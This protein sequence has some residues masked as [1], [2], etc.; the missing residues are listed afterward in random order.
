MLDAAGRWTLP[1]FVSAEQH[2]AEV[3]LVSRHIRERY[4]LHISIL[5]TVASDYDETANRVRK[6]YLAE[7][8]TETAGAGRW[9]PR[10]AV[11]AG[12]A[13]L[14][15]EA[16]SLVERWVT[17]SLG[18]ADAVWSRPGWLAE[19][20]AW[21]ATKAGQIID[22]EQVRVSEFSTVVRIVAG[23]RLC[24]FK[25]VAPAAA[26]EPPVT[27]ALARRTPHVPP[28]LAA[29]AARRFLLLEAFAG[30]PLATDDVAVWTGVARD[31]GELQR[32]CIDAVGE[33][34][35]MGCDVTRARALVEPLPALLANDDA[36]LVGTPAGLTTSEIA[37]LRTLAPGL[38][39][40]A[41]ALDAGPL[42]LTVDHGDLWPSNVLV[43][44]GGCA[45][46][47]WEDARIAHPFVSTFQLLAGAHMDHRFADEM[48]AY[49]AV[50][51]AYLA[52]WSGWAPAPSLRKAFDIAHDVAAV[53]VAASYRRYPPD[54]VAAHPWMREM[55]PFCLRRILT[56]RA[57]ADAPGP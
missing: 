41:H 21:V 36:L 22:V 56:R 38:A 16:H 7:A 55:P 14:R 51:E 50:R 11:A 24:Y 3:E 5:G 52:G 18:A 32:D 46:V 27:A 45:F 19:A 35:A 25:A 57:W 15:D 13:P 47:D 26:R 28:V 2:T 53:A 1:G 30:E 34:R 8:L 54:V 48:A 10:A 9:W 20:L 23:D 31:L 44:P 39:A 40:D 43:G 6:A 4:G 42:P 49:T 12:E 33:L 29:D 37:A 17:G